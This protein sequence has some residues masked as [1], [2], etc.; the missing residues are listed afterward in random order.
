MKEKNLFTLEKTNELLDLL[1]EYRTEKHTFEDKGYDFLDV[2]QYFV[3][4][5]N[6]EETN[7][8]SIKLG[9]EFTLFFGGWHKE[10]DAND[11]GF[12]EM[13]KL[14]QSIIDCSQCVYVLSSLSVSRYAI[15]KVLSEKEVNDRNVKA[16]INAYQEFKG[17]KLKNVKLRL[18]A[19][20]TEYNKEVCF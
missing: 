13:V 14:L 7:N 19:W 12:K 18:I 9:N 4:V 5:R 6:P 10:Y 1:A 8:L 16:I 20:Q 11:E 17:I 3:T 2:G 15:G